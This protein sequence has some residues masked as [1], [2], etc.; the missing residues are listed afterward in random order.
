[1]G[2]LLS[3]WRR[4]IIDTWRKEVFSTV[5]IS[6]AT[7]LVGRDLKAL[8]SALV[9]SV[10]VM[11][12][13]MF[14]HLLCILW[15]VRIITGLHD[16]DP[17]IEVSFIDERKE[18]LS[19]PH[20]AA[21]ELKNAGSSDALWV[22]IAPL[23]LRS[24]ILYFFQVEDAIAPTDFRRF[25]AEVGKQWGYDS[26]HDFIRAMSEEW[27]S[28]EDRVTRREIVVPMLVSYENAQG[29]H[30]ELSFQLLYHGGKGWNQ[31]GDVKCIECRNFS[32]RRIVPGGFIP[33]GARKG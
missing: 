12:G 23:K 5:L 14:Y 16:N 30:Y 2:N 17:R 10:V 4:R 3:E 29:V 18:V 31:T 33:Y 11:G 6:I 13:W 27:V 21:L 15:K 28:H 8:V 7:F 24:R 9:A 25:H 1:M 20:S 32:Y 22:R 19:V 26:N